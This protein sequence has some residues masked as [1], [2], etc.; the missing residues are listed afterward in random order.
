MTIH[1]QEY[2][3]LASD[4]IA[5]LSIHPKHALKILSGE[6]RLEFRRVWA[7]R[8][9]SAVLI[10]VTVP[11]KKIVAIA[12]VRQIHRGTVDAI[13]SKAKLI[14]GG[15]SKSEIVQYFEGKEQCFAIEMMDVYRFP[16][17][18]QPDEFIPQFKAPQSFIYLNEQSKSLLNKEIQSQRESMKGTLTFVGGV[19]GVG[20]TTMCENYARKWNAIHNSA[21]KI[22][23]TKLSS[24]V[25]E[26]AVKDVDYNQ[27]ILISEVK[28]IRRQEQLNLLDGHFS[29][30]NKEYEIQDIHLSVF[31]QL[32]VDRIVVITD[33]VEGIFKRLSGRDEK[34]M[35]IERILLLQRAEIRRAAQVAAELCVPFYEILAGDEKGFESALR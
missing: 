11:V 35:S 31:L 9:V 13:W 22:I 7:T 8:P 26:K 12:K 27:R 4:E 19:H 1:S 20:K 17:P 14:G 10:Y 34:T 30:L 24:A 29:V 16:S 33:D 5:L 3:K 6:K 18:L 32:G 2:W 25:S 21:G 15:L 23:G 28:K